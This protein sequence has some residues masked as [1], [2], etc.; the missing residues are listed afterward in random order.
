MGGMSEYSE[1]AEFVVG[2]HWELA[3][4]IGTDAPPKVFDRF[5]EVFHE[6]FSAVTT[7][8]MVV[9]RDTL[10]GGVF[11]ARNLLPG[12][13][14]EVSEFVELVGVG[15]LVVVRYAAENRV[16]EVRTPRV[17]TASLVVSERGYRLRSLHETAVGEGERPTI[18]RV[19]EGVGL[20]PGVAE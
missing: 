10:L 4:W 18:A 9:D 1:A 11:A 15:E 3:E 8:G 2:L 13:E 17:A 5:S 12:L 20:A 14:I 19:R 6:E 7:A 16:G